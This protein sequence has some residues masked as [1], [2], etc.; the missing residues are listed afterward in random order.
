MQTTAQTVAVSKKNLWTGRII[1][2]LTIVFLL[3]DSIAKLMRAAPVLEA[4]A[5]L[6]IPQNLAV[7][8]GTILLLCVVV[9]AIPRTAVLGAILL[10]GYLG[11]A[12]FTQLRAGGPLFDT[13][14]PVIFGMLIWVAIYLRDSRLGVVLPFRK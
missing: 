7:G 13:L 4:S 5:R 1:T 8:I 9:Y 3:F 6:G 12:V 14:F 10:T 11:G 2:G